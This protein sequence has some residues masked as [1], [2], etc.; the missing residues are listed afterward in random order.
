MRLIPGMNVDLLFPIAEQFRN[1]FQP[2]FV[3]LLALLPPGSLAWL[4]SGATVA[5]SAMDMKVADPRPLLEGVDRNRYDRILGRGAKATATAVTITEPEPLSAIAPSIESTQRDGS[6]G[7]AVLEFVET[8]NADLLIKS[9]FTHS[10]LRQ[11]IFGG[12]TREILESA[13]V[14]TLFCH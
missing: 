11:L 9:A 2:L 12:A 4:A 14:P 3:R 10:R 6:I 5:A 13:P 8:W 1:L 7:E